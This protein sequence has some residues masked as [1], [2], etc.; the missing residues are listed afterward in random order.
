MCGCRCAW[1]LGLTTGSAVKVEEVEEGAEPAE[2]WK[3]LGQKDK[4]A[5]DCMLQGTHTHIQTCTHSHY[6]HESISV[7]FV[8]M[9]LTVALV[10]YTVKYIA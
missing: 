7:A 1:E 6:R 5:Y 4:K 10:V 8:F 9:Q 2:F 3:A